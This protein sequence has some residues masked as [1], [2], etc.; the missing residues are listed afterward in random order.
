[1]RVL[2]TLDYNRKLLERKS[3]PLG[4]AL[5]LLNWN[6]ITYELFINIEVEKKQ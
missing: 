5:D 6:N 2:L 3:G 1:M 4:V